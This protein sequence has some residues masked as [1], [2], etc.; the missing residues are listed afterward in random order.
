[1]DLVASY[2]ERMTAAGV[3]MTAYIANVL[4]SG[5]SAAG[6]IDR[7]REIFDSLVDPPLG[8]AAPHNHF[9]PLG[10]HSVPPDAPVFREPSSWEAIITAEL[11]IGEIDKAQELMTQLD[12]RM[13]PS[14]VTSRI[15]ALFHDF[16][17]FRQPDVYANA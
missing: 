2:V 16:Q 15:R 17:P 3:H 7:A 10:Q 4:I 14:G 9:I 1:V 12:T 13:F 11:R 5:Y 6:D 8:V